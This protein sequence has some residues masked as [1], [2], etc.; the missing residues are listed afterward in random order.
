M[1]PTMPATLGEAIATE[2]LWLQ[3]WVTLRSHSWQAEAVV[4]RE[5]IVIQ[6]RRDLSRIPGTN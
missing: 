6:I 4:E 1:E 5:T 3:V 2:P